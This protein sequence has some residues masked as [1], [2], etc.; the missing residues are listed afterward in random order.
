VSRGVV[1]EGAIG[2]GAIGGGA[3]GGGAIGDR[4]DGSKAWLK[5]QGGRSRSVTDARGIHNG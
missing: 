5:R 4:E 2:E 3:I 1:G